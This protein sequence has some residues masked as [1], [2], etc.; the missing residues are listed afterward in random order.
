MP[1]RRIAGLPSVRKQHLLVEFA[2]L[3]YASPQ[4][5][6]V[7][8][9]PDDPTLWSGVIFV[10][11]GPYSPAILRFQ[12]SFPA[13]FPLLP[14][15]VTFSTDIFHPLLTPLTTYTYTTGSSEADTVS[16]TDDERLP[17]GGFSLRHGFPNWFGRAQR[18]GPGSAI[19]SRNASGTDSSKKPDLAGGSCLLTEPATPI[20]S[21]VSPSMSGG[22]S[23]ASM[24]PDSRLSGSPSSLTSPNVG[25]V[26]AVEVL[27]YIRS[28]FDDEAVLDSLPLEAAG[29]PGAWHAWRAHR[30]ASIPPSLPPPLR[31]AEDWGGLSDGDDPGDA[32][33]AENHRLAG[34]WSVRR[35]GEWN[36]E[37]VWEERVR[38]GIEGSLAEPVLYGNAG[39][40]DDLVCPPPMI[41]GFTHVSRPILTGVNK[42]R[43]LNMDTDTVEAV[44]ENIRCSV[45]SAIA[46]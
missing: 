10:R 6:Y 28:A 19:S 2:S 24:S 27:R 39:M 31:A 37:G 21:A 32:A 25:E 18:N 9:S 15:L 16:A 40:G 36:W 4:G 44:K 38:K 11:K 23:R 13:D 34:G 29:N 22:S 12:I 35:P 14:P 33:P 46:K 20:G 8:L 30:F 42:I 1:S 5:V 3:R 7:S 41:S 45:G 26:S 43:F 17:P